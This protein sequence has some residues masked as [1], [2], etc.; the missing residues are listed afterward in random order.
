MRKR[1]K[2]RLKD[3]VIDFIYDYC[4]NEVVKKVEAKN[5]N[6]EFPDNYPIDKDEILKDIFTGIKKS[7]GAKLYH[8]TRDKEYCKV[9]RKDGKAVN[10]E[11][12]KKLEFLGYKRNDQLEKEV[13][14][15]IEFLHIRSYLANNLP[16]KTEFKL[17]EKGLNH[18]RTGKSFEE[19]YIKGW[20][21]RRALLISGISIIIA[22]ISV[23]LS[24]II[25][26]S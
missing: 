15:T 21:A 19:I 18:Y 23:L 20:V 6:V 5:L 16:V 7:G 13:N 22:I 10:S 12:I 26:N 24:F 14:K 4:W 2:E 3:I 9:I 8:A 17:T 11:F 1:S 25:N